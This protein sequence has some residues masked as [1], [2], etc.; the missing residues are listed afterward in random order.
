[1]NTQEY[2][3]YLKNQ[4]DIYG[5][6]DQDL[7][8]AKKKGGFTNSTYILQEKRKRENLEKQR[9]AEKQK[10][11]LRNR[12]KYT[13]NSKTYDKNYNTILT[14]GEQQGFNQWMSTQENVEDG[15]DYAG[16][17]K[18]EISKGINNGHS[19][20]WRKP[21]HK[22]FTNGSVYDNGQNIGG[23]E[24][25]IITNDITGE[26]KTIQGNRQSVP[27]GW[28]VNGTYYR[29]PQ[30]RIQ[31]E[32]Q[33]KKIREEKAKKQ[34]SK[35]DSIFSGAKNVF[36]SIEDFIMKPGMYKSNDPD[37]TVNVPG[38]FGMSGIRESSTV[39][40]KP[41]DFI[42]KL[43]YKT[44]AAGKL[45]R[46]PFAAITG[47]G[48]FLV[49]LAMD[50]KNIFSPEKSKYYDY[51]KS[52]DDTE[53]LIAGEYSSGD[54]T[55]DFA[56]NT[57]AEAL[58]LGLEIYTT[59]GIVGGTNALLKK[60]LQLGAV[61]VL[62]A[63][64]DGANV[65][66]KS[67]K[68]GKY[69]EKAA[70]IGAKYS[71]N[72]VE[73]LS[74]EGIQASEVDM[75]FAAKGGNA[76]AMALAKTVE[77]IEKNGIPKDATKEER[78]FY[79]SLL[80][81]KDQIK[82]DVIFSTFL[83]ALCF[84]GLGKYDVSK[85]L[86]NPLSKRVGLKGTSSILNANLVDG[87]T[88]AKGLTILKTLNEAKG[89]AAGASHMAAIGTISEFGSAVVD[90]FFLDKPIGYKDL[91][92]G[93]THQLA[94]GG[95]LATP[96]VA[97]ATFGG[98][99]NDVRQT[100]E[101]AQLA[102]EIDK[103]IREN[104][105]KGAE[106]SY[107][108]A[109]NNE[110]VIN[111]AK[112]NLTPEQ[113][114]LAYNIVNGEKSYAGKAVGLEVMKHIDEIPASQRNDFIDC[115]V[116]LSTNKSIS[117]NSKFDEKFYNE[118][119]KPL[120]ELYDNV[121][122]TYD[123]TIKAE[124]VVL[125]DDQKEKVQ[126]FS[127]RLDEYENLDMDKGTKDRIISMYA[128][129]IKNNVEGIENIKQLKL[130]KLR[131]YRT[132]TE[133]YTKESQDSA[134]NL[135]A[136][137]QGASELYW[138]NPER[139]NADIFKRL[140][141]V[142]NGK[143]KTKL[144][145]K[146]FVKQITSELYDSKV[147]ALEQE[148][149]QFLPENIEK[150]VNYFKKH[151]NSLDKLDN[152]TNLEE[153]KTILGD[154]AIY[155]MFHEIEIPEQIEEHPD[156]NPIKPEHLEEVPSHH[157]AQDVLDKTAEAVGAGQ[158]APDDAS[159]IIRTAIER[160]ENSQIDAQKAKL[161]Q[162]DV[163]NA[164][165]YTKAVAAEIIKD[166]VKEN[167]RTIGEGKFIFENSHPVIE[168]RNNLENDITEYNKEISIG[169]D[170]ISIGYDDGGFIINNEVVESFGD[171]VKKY[172]EE[173]KNL[174][175]KLTEFKEQ[176]EPA[177]LVDII[178]DH[179]IPIDEHNSIEYETSNHPENF[180]EGYN[181][182][183]V[184]EE[185]RD[186][187]NSDDD[188]RHS[189]FE[190]K[191]ARGTREPR[192]LIH[193]RL[194]NEE[195]KRINDPLVPD[196]SFKGG[197]LSLSDN[198]RTGIREPEILQKVEQLENI[199]RTI[200]SLP[201]GRRKIA[202]D[203]LKQTPEW[204][205]MLAHLPI[206]YK[207]NAGD[208]FLTDATST[209]SE[210]SSQ[211]GN[212]NR[213]NNVLNNRGAFI[214]KLIL[215]GGTLDGV[216]IE[217]AFVNY[218]K[219]NGWNLH[220]LTPERVGKIVLGKAADIPKY[221]HLYGGVVAQLGPWGKEQSFM[222][223]ANDIGDHGLHN[224]LAGLIYDN[225]MNGGTLKV[226]DSN[227]STYGINT[228]GKTINAS[229]II[230][231]FV[232]NKPFGQDIEVLNSPKGEHIF[233][234]IKDQL[235]HIDNNSKIM[236]HFRDGVRSETLLTPE[237]RPAHVATIA[238]MLK[239][240]NVR[241][242]FKKLKNKFGKLTI[243]ADEDS[244]GDDFTIKD[245]E[246]LQE[247][248]FRN[249]IY[250][251]DVN[252]NEPYRDS[253]M[254]VKFKG[255]S[256]KQEAYSNKAEI[257]ETKK[258]AIKKEEERAKQEAK[259]TKE[260]QKKFD[261][262]Q[263]EKA[264]AVEKAHREAMEK[265][266]E[267]PLDLDPI[268]Y[269]DTVDEA[270]EVSDGPIIPDVPKPVEAKIV[271]KS[272]P[273]EYKPNISKV[274]EP[275]E[276]EK[277]LSDPGNLPDSETSTGIITVV[278]DLKD[279]VTDKYT[280]SE[281]LDSH[282]LKVDNAE[283]SHIPDSY[284]IGQIIKS[285]AHT[286]GKTIV[287][288]EKITAEQSEDLIKKIIENDLGSLKEEDYA[289]RQDELKR[290][291]NY[292]KD[293][294]K[295]I[296]V[297]A[298]NVANKVNTNSGLKA[299][300]DAFSE[301][302]SLGEMMTWVDNHNSID[303]YARCK[304]D[305]LSVIGNINA[306][307]NSA[308][309]FNDISNVEVVKS[310]LLD[311]LCGKFSTK[312]DMLS[313]L[314][315]SD[316]PIIKDF[317][318]QILGNESLITAA[319]NMFHKAKVN[320]TDLGFRRGGKHQ[321]T[322]SEHLLN[323][324][325]SREW[326]DNAFDKITNAADAQK[327]NK[328]INE[329]L[330]QH[331]TADGQNVRPDVD[332]HSFSE[333]LSNALQ[334]AGINVSKEDLG[335]LADARIKHMQ[336]KGVEIDEGNHHQLAYAIIDS[337]SNPQ[338]LSETGKIN[339]LT[340][341]INRND[342]II[343]DLV[344]LVN[345]ASTQAKEIQ[346][347]W[348][349]VKS[350]DFIHNFTPVLS[351]LSNLLDSHIGKGINTFVRDVDGK[352]RYIYIPHS[353]T[354]E[355]VQYR[356]NDINYIY[357]KLRSSYN[358][359]S[360]WL[361]TINNNL[362]EGKENGLK[363]ST[364]LKLYDSKGRE[365]SY[366][367]ATPQ[368]ILLAR[369]GLIMDGKAVMR[370]IEAKE[371]MDIIEG[372]PPFPDP[373]D[374]PKYF[375]HK[376]FGS[377]YKAAIEAQRTRG[378]FLRDVLGLNKDTITKK[379]VDTFNEL[380]S[381]QQ[382]KLNIDLSKYGMVEGYHYHY[383][384][385]FDSGGLHIGNKIVLNGAGYGL[386]YFDFLGDV[387]PSNLKMDGSYDE[388]HYLEI[389][390]NP[391]NIKKIE[392]HLD[393]VIKSYVDRLEEYN[394]IETSSNTGGNRLQDITGSNVIDI[395]GELGSTSTNIAEKHLRSHAS[396]RVTPVDIEQWNKSKD[397][398]LQGLA[399]NK[400]HRGLR[401]ALGVE[402]GDIEAI[403]A[404]TKDG[405]NF[406]MALKIPGNRIGNLKE[407]TAVKQFLQNHGEN[408]EEKYVRTAALAGNIR[409][410][411]LAELYNNLE[412]SRVFEGDPAFYK[413]YDDQTK[414]ISGM[415]SD[416][417]KFNTTYDENHEFYGRTKYK[418]LNLNDVIIKDEESY[419]Q[420]LDK[421]IGTI[422]EPGPA[423]VKAAEGRPITKEL[424]DKVREEQKQYVAFMLKSMTT[425]GQ[426][427]IT[428][429]MAREMAIKSGQWSPMK[430]IAFKRMMN[431]ED[432]D[433]TITTVLKCMNWEP[434]QSEQVLE[435]GST[436]PLDYYGFDKTAYAPLFP[437]H[438]KNTPLEPIINYCIANDIGIIS[439]GSSRKVGGSQKMTAFDGNGDLQFSPG[440]KGD[441]YTT[442]HDWEN[443][444][445]QLPMDPHKVKDQKVGVQIMKAIF[446]GATPEQKEK[447]HN[448]IKG[449]AKKNINPNILDTLSNTIDPDNQIDNVLSTIENGGDLS[450][451]N[452]PELVKNVLHIFDD[453]MQTKIPGGSSVQISDI[454]RS[455][456]SKKLRMQN[457][458]GKMEIVS[459][460]GVLSGSMPKDAT[461]GE[462][463]F[464]FEK[465]RKDVGA[466]DMFHYRIPTQTAISGDPTELV[467]VVSNTAGDVIY[468]PHGA[469]AKK[470]VD[471]DAD[472]QFYMV[473]TYKVTPI[474]IKSPKW[475]YNRSITDKFEKYINSAR[476]V[477]KAN[478]VK[479]GALVNDT[480]FDRN[481]EAHKFAID[482]YCIYDEKSGSFLTFDGKR[483]EFYDNVKY[484][485]ANTNSNKLLDMYSDIYKNKEMNLITTSSV[486]G[487]TK[488]VKDLM[489]D[490]IRMPNHKGLHRISSPSLVD[491]RSHSM[492]G[493]SL[494]GEFAL[495]SSMK[496]LF[497]EAFGKKTLMAF[498]KINIFD[499]QHSEN[500]FKNYWVRSDRSSVYDKDGRPIND[501]LVA[502]TSMSVDSP[503]DNTPLLAN[504]NEY[505]KKAVN[506]LALEGHGDSSIALIAQPI[507][508][509]HVEKSRQAVYLNANYKD[510]RADT[511]RKYVLKLKDYNHMDPE[512]AA[513]NIVNSMSAAEHHEILTTESL[514]ADAIRYKNEGD[515]VLND[516]EY[517]KRQIVRYTDFLIADS[518]ARELRKYLVVNN[519]DK[520]SEGIG[521]DVGGVVNVLTT[522]RDLNN[523]QGVAIIS[524]EGMLEGDKIK[525]MFTDKYYISEKIKSFSEQLQYAQKAGVVD[526]SNL[527]LNTFDKLSEC[528]GGLNDNQRRQIGTF[529]RQELWG[530]EIN[531]MIE[532]G[533]IEGLSSIK[534]LYR[535][536]NSLANR[537]IELTSNGTIRPSNIIARYMKV[538]GNGVDTHK[539]LS[540]DMRDIENKKIQD[541]IIK[542]FRDF[543]AEGEKN[544]G[545]EFRQFMRDFII[546]SY[547]TS[548]PQSHSHLIPDD[549]ISKY[550]G[551]IISVASSNINSSNFVNPNDAT[552]KL[553]VRTNSLDRAKNIMSRIAENKK[554]TP[555]FKVTATKKDGEEDFTYTVVGLRDAE[556][557]THL[558]AKSGT[559]T[560]IGIKPLHFDTMQDVPAINVKLP[561][562]KVGT[563]E[564]DTDRQVYI[565]MIKNGEENEGAY[566][567]EGPGD[568]SR[569]RNIIY[570]K[571]EPPKRLMEDD[572]KTKA[573]INELIDKQPNTRQDV[574]SSAYETMPEEIPG[575]SDF[576]WEDRKDV[577]G[578]DFVNLGEM[579]TP[580]DPNTQFK[581]KQAD[582]ASINKISE[583]FSQ[584]QQD[585]LDYDFNTAIAMMGVD[586][587][588]VREVLHGW[589]DSHPEKV[590]NLIS[591][592]YN[593]DM[594]GTIWKSLTKQDKKDM[595]DKLIWCP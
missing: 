352:K 254:H 52:L 455:P 188:N 444:R 428:P 569:I 523:E 238:D 33:L 101:S 170:K 306:G 398:L 114:A 377:E 385:E 137:L 250:H 339:S 521:S 463:K 333:D 410:A 517:V 158:I 280:I 219:E 290:F 532:G 259:E 210:N 165:L 225:A 371:R 140:L 44:N 323:R 123:P 470:G 556:P 468:L 388:N 22:N 39:K 12:N 189:N 499:N 452:N 40:A 73:A 214:E 96:R 308:T 119:Y 10:S 328:A 260:L 411:A 429:Y 94:V 222:V 168:L 255:D 125:D 329:L 558:Q 28:S 431:G 41:T 508:F 561:D 38:T 311:V 473:K 272:V 202:L 132:E 445:W 513:M 465:I 5:W 448:V 139:Y 146:T 464:I 588:S 142:A 474:D 446:D 86:I 395:I 484:E 228:H 61:D 19:E 537:F 442:E 25:L 534:S 392:E 80:E 234:R 500:A 356:L 77:E 359:E 389:I 403:R 451:L 258:E 143:I 449:I 74:N 374:A 60:A 205:D 490:M 346:A 273:V 541:E 289:D 330:S 68:V 24:D 476:V 357:N 560:V 511:L 266:E 543:C 340:G 83:T 75:G 154:Q 37:A 436:A 67:G 85:N 538:K 232:Q 485:V 331:L 124:D 592:K 466:V 386:R 503:K 584:A 88:S 434:Q 127:Q 559:T 111:T 275:F 355:L 348:G 536:E 381:K 354:S 535:G 393:E 105:T 467:D 507:V 593:E 553:S 321:Q 318:Q 203:K 316:N 267:K 384:P 252:L 270:P 261:K 13:P 293:I 208:Y 595:I 544:G 376:Y 20:T 237:G 527:S 194:Q 469:P 265:A 174:Y 504:L 233:E 577:N 368:D 383:E 121:E 294:L 49:K 120:A 564:R 387:L 227:G 400:S 350:S 545:E 424:L 492:G 585:G 426:S 221:S 70:N 372:M 134:E 567:Y 217:R 164:G 489:K 578:I 122:G 138:N 192:A 510:A 497:D 128:Q 26:T 182:D 342:N 364:V 157:E 399:T 223:Y 9:E 361:N 417:I 172:H 539:Y 302:D 458:R 345:H 332:Y 240:K 495:G 589:L 144:D 204:N 2:N 72:V 520:G 274:K 251:S 243:A 380:T 530:S 334:M 427:F 583:A 369:H 341:R 370:Q 365:R 461:I 278:S 199:F 433:E 462:Q 1:M 379:D 231:A 479:R 187:L 506:I 79:Q 131:E 420:F 282:T 529:V 405:R 404:I 18:N 471:N 409:F 190:Q 78:A 551:D 133:G 418:K 155:D 218:N 480:T 519:I 117:A 314:E 549:V 185:V 198:W 207:C 309:T 407:F 34:I 104:G 347:K 481:A 580:A 51:F 244:M 498:K 136:T 206:K 312:E 50:P 45:F 62:P 166:S 586:P 554:F 160:K 30:E 181:E 56:V 285:L 423:L 141:E 48:N 533:K 579:F 156:A 563:F 109:F 176:K 84:A 149:D 69:L 178:K 337:I 135:N 209:Y 87:V 283:F 301:N 195:F 246:T 76:K 362:S 162:S 58:G 3:Q 450:R 93:F 110:S 313:I 298:P 150:L 242:D 412:S 550:A 338:F 594:T 565:R 547:I 378:A 430:E 145:K 443:L 496:P 382:D 367:N 524:P 236:T 416:G 401:N 161:Y 587:K 171:L 276:V 415:F 315:K 268:M 375:S 230:S 590:E 224:A 43:G 35:T 546:H 287:A 112:K 307:H 494:I 441:I 98:I 59:A 46:A 488:R 116:A 201:E 562:G 454:G 325:R 518:N 542:G 557:I 115:V 304:S 351:R 4:A 7:E 229:D 526:L 525:P 548:S 269:E 264:K 408:V 425:D 460:I 147:K 148:L 319:F 286:I 249:G 57:A 197:L 271:E 391:S 414:R 516:P 373:E 196:S 102:S 456:S 353:F 175:N 591:K 257:E 437:T 108:T 36:N 435:N 216:D 571:V 349:P 15:Y 394:M 184:H 477:D 173:L 169:E 151:K 396:S 486:D 514:K 129:K 167:S 515:R 482:N 363:Y 130:E 193:P 54:K 303:P 440:E 226:D 575:D 292:R 159:P 572:D 402:E 296:K 501:L 288:D 47:T 113:L 438:Y 344:N 453:V 335:I 152:K 555:K 491:S 300:G 21:T 457:D 247:A 568:N 574:E 262:Q 483:N 439:F 8:V 326:S 447:M 291:V 64:I 66:S 31:R 327:I 99:K 95:L 421:R 390:N 502:L 528:F 118:N 215:N 42:P 475:K 531:K 320:Y 97:R 512:T 419:K 153:L 186:I 413:N 81:K 297:I 573:A 317:Q 505:T 65:V 248:L 107:V 212:I 582:E 459:N 63:S 163:Q 180:D 213:R 245:G 299:K 239:G 570:G 183:T 16:Q 487:P 211:E 220:Q 336:T 14:P 263:E 295:N 11:L 324:R 566:F 406:D 472:K 100:K 32:I 281:P 422:E 576:H 177:Q 55:L 103:H 200:T 23:E 284:T 366:G 91:V 343:T 17:Y 432:V 478:E 552:T 397:L 235:F 522:L 27:K 277:A 279:H 540:L 106:E 92:K 358:A 322:S 305:L 509:D 581:G 191:L 493:S 179:D 53:Q 126:Q 71:N 82:N 310:N 89:V 241:P 360:A 256:N 6:S 253:Q 29:T 90:N